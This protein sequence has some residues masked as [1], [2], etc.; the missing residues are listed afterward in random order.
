MSWRRDERR[1][2]IW[3]WNQEQWLMRP[4]GSGVY[5][6]DMSLKRDLA[7]RMRDD[8]TTVPTKR[9][10]TQPTLHSKYEDRVE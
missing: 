5:G 7:A 2:Q 6:T 4:G 1:W 8:G 10:L 9:P 3:E